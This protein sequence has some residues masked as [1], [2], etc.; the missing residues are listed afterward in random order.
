MIKIRCFGFGFRI[1]SATAAGV[2]EFVV[3]IVMISR[4]LLSY[5]SP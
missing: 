5:F 4:W 3:S 1:A 2:F